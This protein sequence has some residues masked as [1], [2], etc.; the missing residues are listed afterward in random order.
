[1]R[2]WLNIVA[3]SACL[4]LAPGCVKYHY[5]AAPPDVRAALITDEALKRVEEF[6]G[7]VI[8]GALAGSIP[9]PAARTAVE[10]TVKVATIA[11]QQPNGWQAVAREAW[12]QT[13]PQLALVPQLAAWLGVLDALLG[14]T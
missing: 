14:G 13:R 8:D 7:F 12:V 9:M 2:F 11:K 1:M 3:M 6:Q 4:V 10:W 5:I